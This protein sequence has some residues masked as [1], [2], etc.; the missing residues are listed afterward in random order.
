MYK[1][2]FKE[3]D[4]LKFKIDTFRPLTNDILNSRVL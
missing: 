2:R 1:N 4:E 3:I